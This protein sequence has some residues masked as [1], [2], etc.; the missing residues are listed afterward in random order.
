LFSNS[1]LSVIGHL[2]RGP[3]SRLAITRT[4][5]SELTRVWWPPLSLL[6]FWVCLWPPLTRPSLLSD[7]P[8]NHLI[9]VNLIWT[10]P[11]GLQSCIFYIA[12]LLYIFAFHTIW[13]FFVLS[14]IPFKCFVS[15]NLES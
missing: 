4:I 10:V 15:I 1:L 9:W 5:W 2:S 7:C 14:N 8:K 12:H 11:L 6:S 3:A 13:F